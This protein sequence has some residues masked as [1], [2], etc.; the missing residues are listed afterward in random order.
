[1]TLPRK[2]EERNDPKISQLFKPHGEEK[3]SGNVDGQKQ[4]ITRSGDDGF[5]HLPPARREFGELAERYQVYFGDNR[6]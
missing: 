5:H 2:I 1:M 3:W 4:P 6:R